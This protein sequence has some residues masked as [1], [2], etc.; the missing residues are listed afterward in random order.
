MLRRYEDSEYA[1]DALHLMARS[2]L[3][4][5]RY[6]DAAAAFERFV[7]RFPDHE[8][9]PSAR[10][11]LARAKRLAGDATGAEAALAA[12]AEA[13]ESDLEAGILHERALVALASGDNRAAVQRF[14]A[15]LERH[16]EYAHRAGVAMRF[17]DAELAIGEVDAAL[18]VYTMHRDR[19]VDPAEKREAGLKMARALVATGRVDEALETYDSLLEEGRSDFFAAQV[20][21]ERGEVLAE[22]EKW[23]EAESSFRRAAEVAPGTPPASRATLGRGRIAWRVEGDREAALEILLDAFLHAPTSAWG[24]TARTAARDV[25]EI[26]HYQRLAEGR[27]EV[28]SV[29]DPALV[30]ST[31]LYRLAEEVLDVE[32][33]PVAAA[34]IFERLVE[35]HPDSPWRSRALLSA[36]LLRRASGDVGAGNA[37]L[38]RLV[39]ADP[40][41]PEADSARRA[42]G[43]PVPDRPEGFYGA[44]PVL[45]TVARALPA[46]QDPMTRISDQLDRYATRREAR[47]RE[48]AERPTEEI[49]AAPG[50]GDPASDA[51]G[52]PGP[53]DREAPE[54]LPEGAEP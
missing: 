47:E 24:D 21:A 7:A 27:E 36:G 23:E 31:A 34:A 9:V 25:A 35:E 54:R 29:D 5:G 50:Q 45:V 41:S 4:L 30:R 11:G 48:E 37:L 15:L 26:L 33:D 28:P 16:P 22:Q 38:R 52:Q 40:E 42:L 51:I 19:V 18:E 2:F 8:R 43:A 44:R 17:A 1:D 12:I 49:R 32:E 46:P 14:R 10:L 53:E 6:P 39:E 3:R 20:H 13:G